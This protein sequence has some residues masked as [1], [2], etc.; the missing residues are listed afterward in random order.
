MGSILYHLLT[1]KPLFSEYSSGAT[2]SA[3]EA[4]EI[5]VAHRLQEPLAPTTGKEPH[6]D[7]LVLRL[8]QKNPD[9]RYQT[10]FPSEISANLSAKG[11]IH[12]LQQIA[13]RDFFTMGS[14]RIGEVDEAAKFSFPSRLSLTVCI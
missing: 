7:E 10:G 11:L 1:G 12:D 8:L 3:E 5:A 13:T 2:I 14:L 4:L 6:L 9:R